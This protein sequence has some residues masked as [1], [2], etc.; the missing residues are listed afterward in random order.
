M[1]RE[2]YSSISFCGNYP[3]DSCNLFSQFFFLGNDWSKE[4]P[5]ASAEDNSIGGSGSVQSE[6]EAKSETGTST[7]IKTSIYQELDDA[8][9]TLDQEAELENNQ[10][11]NFQSG[12]QQQQP[13]MMATSMPYNNVGNA[14]GL[15]YSSPTS[16]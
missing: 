3:K 16:I 2:N 13:T 12:A 4:A 5:M 10:N 7:A 15:V 9:T 11:Y 6:A 14:E 1:I 8:F